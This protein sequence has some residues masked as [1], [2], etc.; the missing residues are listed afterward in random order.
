MELHIQN[1]GKRYSGDKWALR[2]FSL[3]LRPGILG[4]LGPWTSCPGRASDREFSG[5]GGIADLYSAF[6]V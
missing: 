5:T 3:T 2:D 4:L 1:V 6:A